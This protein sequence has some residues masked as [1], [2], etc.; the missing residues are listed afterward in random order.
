MASEHGLP[1]AL[2]KN[3]FE[4][5]NI[6]RTHRVLKE[7][8]LGRLKRYR[9]KRTGNSAALQA[10]RPNHVWCL[11]FVHDSCLNGAKLKILS[12]VDEFTRECLALEVDTRLNARRVQEVLSPVMAERGAPAFVRTDN[13]SEFIARILAVFL[14]QSGSKSHFIA[15]GSP[16]QNAF[17]ESFHSTLRREHLDVEAFVNLADAQVKTAV[18]RRW[19]NDQRPHSSLGNI[20]PTTVASRIL[21]S[22]RATPSFLLKSGVTSTTEDSP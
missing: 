5:L 14:S 19:Y 9:K 2:V 15:P 16:W 8:R 13:G 1:D 20:P 7:L 3:E 22:S 10:D 18:W 17:V 11:D 12:V 21:E 6:K 4:P